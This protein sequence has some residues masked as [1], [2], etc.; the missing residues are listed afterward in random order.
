V[1][2]LLDVGFP[3]GIV[4][5]RAWQE[6]ARSGVRGVYARCGNGNDQPDQTFAS[7]VQ[8]AQAAGLA[9]GPYAVG[10]PLP[11]SAPHPGREPGSQALL[12]FTASKGVGSHP[13]DLPPALDLEWPAPADWLKWGITAK[14]VREW[15]VD[16]LEAAAKL[17]KRSPILYLYP[18]FWMHF[19]DGA[20]DAELEQLAD[21]DLWLARYGVTSPGSLAGGKWSTPT[22]WQKS[23][24]GGRLPSGAPVDEDVFIGDEVS[25][26]EF[27]D[28]PPVTVRNDV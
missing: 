3:Q 11:A 13:G 16:Y 10:F 15:T 28:L 12:H 24:G 20:T 14:S 19:A 6:I 9:V 26:R 8:G 4:T 23:D 22:L 17:W 27:R 18:D 2:S 7:N 21:Y 25:W 5:M 1:I